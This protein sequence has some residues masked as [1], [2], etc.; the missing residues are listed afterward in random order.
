MKNA[1][2]RHFS[3]ERHCAPA[4]YI[5]VLSSCEVRRQ[6]QFG[7]ATFENSSLLGWEKTG[8]KS[9]ICAL[10]M[11]STLR[12]ELTRRPFAPF[13]TPSSLESILKPQL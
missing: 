5:S 10:N 13:L 9:I 7:T 1:I 6:N 11:Y 2:K 8:M 3:L 4:I 12:S